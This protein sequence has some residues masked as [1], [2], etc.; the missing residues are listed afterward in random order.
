MTELIPPIVKN[1]YVWALEA[2]HKPDKKNKYKSSS[3]GSY[4]LSPESRVALAILVAQA[5]PNEL[6]IT[7]VNYND[8]WRD[9]KIGR[10]SYVELVERGFITAYEA[11]GAEAKDM[12]LEDRVEIVQKRTLFVVRVLLPVKVPRVHRR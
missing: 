6:S 1:M 4:T 7:H 8:N 2:Q 9:Y 10:Y 11:G 12:T 5:Y 3:G